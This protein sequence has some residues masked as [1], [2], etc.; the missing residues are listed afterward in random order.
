MSNTYAYQENKPSLNLLKVDADSAAPIANVTFE[1]FSDADCQQKVGEGTSDSN[2]KLSI[3]VDFGTT[4]YY[5]KEKTPATG[6]HPNGKVYVVTAET[7][8]VV[9]NAGTDNAFTEKQLLLNAT[10]LDGFDEATAT[11]TVKNTA[12]KPLTIQVKKVWDDGDYHARPESVAA[13]LYRDGVEYERVTLNEENGWKHIWSGDAYT[14]AYSW[15][16]DEAETPEE[17]GKVVANEG[18]S[19]TITNKRDPRNVE[20]SV[21]KAWNH[22]GGK[23]L[24]ESITVTLYRN[25]TRFDEVA[26]NAANNWSHTWSGTDYTDAAVWRVDE[27]EIPTGY[28][29]AITSSGHS[30]TITNTRTINP[31]EVS[32]KKVWVASDGVQ[33]PASIE[34]VL[35]RDGVEHETVKLDA[36]NNWCH[37]W[38]GLTDEYTWTVDEKEVPAGYTKSVTNSGHN[39]TITNTQDFK[40]INVS[41]SKL[42]YGNGG[43][44]PASVKVTLLR[45]GQ[46]VDNVTLNAANDWQYIWTNLTD[47]FEW[48]VDELS[49]PSSYNKTVRLYNDYNFVITN[50]HVSVVQS[51]DDSNRLDMILLGL[52]GVMGFAFT[53]I[54][55]FAPRKKGKHQH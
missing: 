37:T 48:E 16:V 2:G 41:V 5:L 9:K 29:R 12:I 18:D 36:A 35:Y 54:Q 19:W 39:Y 3:D 21:T 51:G 44:H 30:F 22:N 25:G 45:D 1:L 24:P 26:L 34:A 11:Y 23:E 40:Y 28:T 33:H 13:V 55:L 8:Y 14:D 6:Y 50:T 53:T 17:Y 43:N 7:R 32:V 38:S 52:A 47:E 49:V 4:S 31:V 10:G 46:A 15:T 42:W 27:T 20:I